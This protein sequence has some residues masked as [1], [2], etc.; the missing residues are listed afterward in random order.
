[1]NRRVI[2]VLVAVVLAIAGAGLVINYVRGSDARAI[3]DA[4]AVPVYVAEQLV[5]SGTT[6][7][8]AVRTELGAAY[9]AAF[10]A[11]ART[12]DPADADL[13]A[14]LLLAWLLGLGQIRAEIGAG[15]DRQAVAHVLRAARVLLDGPPPNA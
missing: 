5:P 1:M 13:R 12:D 15:D 11:Q 10:A 2:A 4:K 3:A 14:T 9:R 8:D 7:K 6:L